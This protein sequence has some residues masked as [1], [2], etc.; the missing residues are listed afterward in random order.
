MVPF[1]FIVRY[2]SVSTHWKSYKPQTFRSGAFS[3]RDWGQF[4]RPSH[5][6]T[7]PEYLVHIARFQYRVSGFCSVLNS[8]ALRV[9]TFHK[10]YCMSGGA[11]LRLDAILELCHPAS[12]ILRLWQTVTVGTFT[13]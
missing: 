7:G 6:R 13:S 4:P 3:F 1:I 5:N 10:A 8:P 12:Y 11:L 2:S 9:C